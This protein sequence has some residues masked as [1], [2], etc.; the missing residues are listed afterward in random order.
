VKSVVTPTLFI[1]GELDND[2]HITQAEE[3]FIGLKRRGIETIF[4][5]YPREGHGIRE[6]AHR[7]DYLNRALGWFDRFIRPNVE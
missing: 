4:V 7:L 3:M 1:H 2:V 6:P 5:R